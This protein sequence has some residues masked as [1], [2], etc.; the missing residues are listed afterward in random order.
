MCR[1][2]E[3]PV[4]PTRLSEEEGRDT[5][6]DRHTPSLHREPRL[7]SVTQFY[8]RLPQE[9]AKGKGRRAEASV[10]DNKVKE[11][12]EGRKEGREG[13]EKGGWGMR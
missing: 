4:E 11:E 13:R 6:T 8:Q 5:E 10:K 1:A 3:G 12:K 9:D 7:L 2:A